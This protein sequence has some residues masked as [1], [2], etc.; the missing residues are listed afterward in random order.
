M[1]FASHAR[2]HAEQGRKPIEI[3]QS[4]PRQA[5]WAD[6]GEGSRRRAQRAPAR[7]HP[8]AGRAP[9]ATRGGRSAAANQEA[10][11]DRRRW[12]EQVVKLSAQRRNERCVLW[13]GRLRGGDSSELRVHGYAVY[14]N[15]IHSSSRH[16][17]RRARQPAD[18]RLGRHRHA[19]AT[20]GN[21]TLRC[22]RGVHAAIESSCG[23]RDSEREIERSSSASSAK[24][25]GAHSSHVACAVRCREAPAQAAA[26]RVQVA[27]MHVYGLSRCMMVAI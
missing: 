11:R 3:G 12:P 7:R 27:G 13:R 26:A 2:P 25:N 5:R 1:T 18:G 9:P 21:L 14:V 23:E 8:Q 20:L 22:S 19:V 24:L 17:H 4:L 15:A 6:P 10:A 16:R